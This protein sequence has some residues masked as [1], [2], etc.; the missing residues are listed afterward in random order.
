MEDKSPARLNYINASRGL[1]ILMVIMLHVSYSVK[2]LSEPFMYM[3][4]KGAFGVQLFFVVSAFTLYRSYAFRYHLE[5]NTREYN[6]FI[7]RIFR[8]VPLY[9]LAIVFYAVIFYYIPSYN[10]GKPLVAWKVV[11]NVLFVNGFIPGS[12]NYLPPGGWSVAIEMIFYCCMPF[13]FARIRNLR[14]ALMLFIILTV[15]A[16]ILKLAIRYILIRLSISYQGPEN[17]FLYYWFPNQAA[18]FILGVILFFA[19]QKYRLR[20]AGL[21]KLAIASTSIA[22]ILFVY[23]KRKIDPYNIIPEHI[24]SAAFLTVIVFLLAQKPARL[25]D[26][27]LTRFLG[28]ISFSLYLIHFI[29]IYG[30]AD[31]VILEISPIGQYFARLALTLVISASISAFTYKFVEL[32]GIEAGKHFLRKPVL[33]RKK[34]EV[35]AV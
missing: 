15:G 30:L 12:I 3:C 27:K 23:I 10:D 7:R 8:I 4:Q 25:Y 31:L 26:N 18:V 9:Y 16:V 28:K 6:F 14:T 32:K 20:K 19:L 1:A 11:M 21:V 17:W 35:Q 29:V 5:G 33:R 24:I 34:A 2:G 13:L 22:L